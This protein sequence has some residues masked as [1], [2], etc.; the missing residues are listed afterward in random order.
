MTGL[1]HGGA[2]GSA[3]AHLSLAST[4][5]VVLGDDCRCW[6]GRRGYVYAQNVPP[7]RYLATVTAADGRAWSAEVEIEPG[8]R[9]VAELDANGPE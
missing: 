3:D 2:S 1:E 5:G 8:E 4:D 9:A 7:G 6:R